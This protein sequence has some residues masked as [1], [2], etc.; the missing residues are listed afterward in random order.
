METEGFCELLAFLYF[1]DD[2]SPEARYYAEGIK[3]NQDKLYGDGFRYLRS[4][5]DTHSFIPLVKSIQANGKIPL[6]TRR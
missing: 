4:V 3:N 2:A 5:C 1:E 6:A